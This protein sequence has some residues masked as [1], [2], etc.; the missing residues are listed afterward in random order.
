MSQYLLGSDESRA[1]HICDR[2]II[3]FENAQG[4]S[5]GRLPVGGGH[6]NIK[7]IDAVGELYVICRYGRRAEIIFVEGPVRAGVDGNKSGQIYAGN[8]VAH[9]EVCIKTVDRAARDRA[10]NGFRRRRLFASGS[11]AGA[12]GAGGQ[13]DRR[14]N[15]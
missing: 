4:I 2:H 7:R 3:I 9:F 13:N 10:E 12:D 14:D 15:R 6:D 11:I 5:L 8:A 1:V